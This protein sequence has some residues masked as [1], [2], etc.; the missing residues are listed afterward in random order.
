MKK[1]LVLLLLLAMAGIASADI[2]PDGG[3]ESGMWSG[4]G[5]IAYTYSSA[6]WIWDSTG[7]WAQAFQTGDAHAGNYAGAF[8][9]PSN[10]VYAMTWSY[11]MAGPGTYD[12]SGGWGWAAAWQQGLAA[13]E[14]DVLQASSYIKQLGGPASSQGLMKIE[15]IDASGTEISEDIEYFAATSDW[16][17]ITGSAFTAPAGTDSV[18]MVV[19]MESWA[20]GLMG[21]TVAFDNVA[22][23]IIPEPMSIALLGLGGLFL[24]RRK[25]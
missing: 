23:D 18:T 13:N 6:Y 10:L 11:A 19:G 7:S 21:S 8:H 15:W 17:Q 20:G 14:G 22:L 25:A 24:R 2:M 12:F 1:L 9:L 4:K 3:F 16:T 5:G